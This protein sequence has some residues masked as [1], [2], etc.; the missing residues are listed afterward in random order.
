[1]LV[2]HISLVKTI[3]FEEECTTTGG[4]EECVAKYFLLLT[5]PADLRHCTTHLVRYTPRSLKKSKQSVCHIDSSYL[6][7]S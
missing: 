1:M 3:L 2:L 4:M 7:G 6:A 5:S